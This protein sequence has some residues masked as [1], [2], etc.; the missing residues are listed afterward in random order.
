MKKFNHEIIEVLNNLYSE[1]LK[2]PLFSYRTTRDVYNLL[3]KQNPQLSELNYFKNFQQK[4]IKDRIQCV[5]KFNHDNL[6]NNISKSQNTKPKSNAF[7]ILDWSNEEIVEQLTY[8][9]TVEL[10]LLQH[11]EFLGGKFMKKDKKITSPTIIKISKRFDDLIMFVIQD[12]LSYD[13]KRIRAKIIEKWISISHRCKVINNFNDSMAIIQALTHFIIQKL[14][15]TWKYVS[16][17]SK[18]VYAILKGLYSCDGN[19]RNLRN[20]IDNCKNVPYV[21][22]LGILLRDINFYEEKAKYLENGKLINFEKISIVQDVIENFYKFEDCA[23][24]FT[25]NDRLTFFLSLFP[26]KEEDL[27]E[28]GNKLEPKFKLYK[29]KK[30]EKR[31]T[32]VDEIFFK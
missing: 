10:S 32:L 5:N 7:Y 27:E 1:I 24:A 18:K 19:Y 31:L 15:R 23:Y 2:E 29:K 6:N 13:H 21:P 28:L 9:S 22:Y 3:I 25:K 12:I 30:S 20:E 11:K 8:I 14:K 26:I 17:E 16:K 4:K